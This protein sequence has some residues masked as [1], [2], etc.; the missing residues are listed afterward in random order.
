MGGPMSAKTQQEMA[1]SAEI[2]PFEIAAK[3]APSGTKTGDW[4]RTL[5]ADA[6]FLS[7]AKAGSPSQSAFFDRWGIAAIIPEAVMLAAPHRNNS[8][9]FEF[10]WVDSQ[11]FSEQNR[12]VA[13]LPKPPI[14]DTEAGETEDG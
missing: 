6:F 3:T 8:L 5:P 1:E 12:F 13:L 4:L 11:K 2:I 14:P 9:A 7:K 10:F